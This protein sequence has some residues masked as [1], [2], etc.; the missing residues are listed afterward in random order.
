MALHGSFVFKC[1]LYLLL[2]YMN[3]GD[4]NRQVH[5]TICLYGICSF[6]VGGLHRDLWAAG[7]KNYCTSFSFHTSSVAVEKNWRQCHFLCL[8]SCNSLTKQWI[9]NY[10]FHWILYY[11]TSTLQSRTIFTQKRRDMLFW[12]V[13]QHWLVDSY[14]FRTTYLSHLQGSWIKHDLKMGPIGCPKC[15]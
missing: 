11:W 5:S 8:I 12:H 15:W 3:F 10:C 1:L 4:Q 9:L 14:R 6:C 2:A 13:T 7:G